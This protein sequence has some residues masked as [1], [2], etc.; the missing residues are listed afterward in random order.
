[1]LVGLRKTEPP[2][3]ACLTVRS[4]SLRSLATLAPLA[5]VRAT[6]EPVTQDAWIIESLWRS[7]ARSARK[8]GGRD[9]GALGERCWNAGRMVWGRVAG[10]AIPESWFTQ[11]ESWTT[12]HCSM[13]NN[14][15]MRSTWITVH[16]N[17]IEGFRNRA[18]L[19]KIDFPVMA[20]IC[21]LRGRC[22][23]WYITSSKSIQTQHR[24][25]WSLW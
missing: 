20:H 1:M 12:F 6:P 21:D 19:A 16:L 8:V 11:P 5:M 23:K 17:S 25:S 4:C 22:S 10:D 24:Q 14:T 2:R 3:V 13:W 7:H 9:A 18:K 15:L